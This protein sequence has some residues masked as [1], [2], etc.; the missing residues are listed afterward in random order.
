M[1]V[2]VYTQVLLFGESLVD[3]LKTHDDVEAWS[4]H[5]ARSLVDEVHQHAADLVLFDMTGEQALDEGRAVSDSYPSAR[6]LAL[7]VS[8][9]A[10]EVIA[11]ADAGFVGY[12]PCQAS[13]DELWS[14]MVKALRDECPCSPQIVGSLWRELRRRRP[15]A[16]LRSDATS[17]T[18]RQRQILSLVAQGLSN[19]EIA[20][21]LNLSIATVKN[22]LH[23]IFSKLGVGGRAEALARLRDEPWLV[24]SARGASLL[25][26]A[27]DS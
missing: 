9:T 21:Q 22:H 24:R 18:H 11:C 20:R 4:C 6:L 10:G 5:S 1:R 7:A 16:G 2:V 15:G 26:V 17:L 8:E 13:L 23:N 14:V 27:A 19:K 3:W 12:V 25:R